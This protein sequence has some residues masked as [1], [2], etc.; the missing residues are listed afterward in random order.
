MSIA[1][2]DYFK[3][4]PYGLGSIK[5]LESKS[6][7]IH[8]GLEEPET[9]CNNM[10]LANDILSAAVDVIESI[11]CNDERMIRLKR[12]LMSIPEIAS[13]PGWNDNKSNHDYRTCTIANC[14][15]CQALIEAGL[16]LSCD[17]CGLVGDART[18]WEMQENGNLLCLS[19]AKE[20]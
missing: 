14:P 18:D 3:Q 20:K 8:A 17:N 4:T 2:I 12:S 10:F 7:E 9:I 19:C 5:E 13:R 6:A 16:I 15:E 11:P 1:P